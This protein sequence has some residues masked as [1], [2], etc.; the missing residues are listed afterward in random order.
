MELGNEF[1]DTYLRYTEKTESPRVFHIWSAL[2]G[3]SSCMGRRVFLQWGDNV[4]HPN[5]FIILV[6]PPAVRKNTAINIMR[7]HLETATNVRF[8]PD[9]TGG[10]RQGLIAAMANEA[11]EDYAAASAALV[12]ANLSIEA[13]ENTE[14]NLQ[15]DPRD[16]TAMTIAANELTSFIGLNE[17]KMITF[18]IKMY[19][20][21]NYDYR[22]KNETRVLRNPLLNLVAGTTPGALAESLPSAA[23]SSGFTSRVILVFG[24]QKARSIPRPVPLP[25]NER[26]WLMERL[27][28]INTQFD[29]EM[30][31]NDLGRKL[32]ERIYEED[33][34]INDPRFVYYEG[35]RQQH[36]IKVAMCLAAGEKRRIITETDILLARTILS[37]TEKGMPDA[38]GEYGLS[39]LGAA[40]Q[41]LVEFLQA[42]KDAISEEVLWAIMNR[43]MKRTDFVN[44]LMELGAAGKII[45]VTTQSGSKAYVA[46][47]KKKT[48]LDE[49][50]TTLL[51]EEDLMNAV[52]NVLAPPKHNQN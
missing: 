28:W 1:L 30:C 7:K 6:G 45:P 46:V 2:W 50:L 27:N 16:A 25:V 20:G 35:R 51:T 44:V 8:A 19:D 47:D 40:K 52:E 32:L 17:L 21:D 5:Q 36:M 34:E 22:L 49:H 48:L 33:T 26:E 31:E 37:S 41:S 10:Q 11:D 13:L 3:L 23:M 24:A 42:A 43:H 14:F 38:L 4:I 15:I 12:D 18:L 39:P 29:G 9:D